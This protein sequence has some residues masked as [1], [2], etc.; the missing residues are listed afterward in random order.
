[1]FSSI[2]PLRSNILL[3][4]QLILLELGWWDKQP[5]ND[6]PCAERG[7]ICVPLVVEV[8]GGCGNEA[9]HVFSRDVKKLET[10]HFWPEV[11]ATIYCHFCVP[12]C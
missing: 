2:N 12:E 8:F 3:G 9:Q 6:V 11:L 10:G 7:W 5:K 1:M 4:P